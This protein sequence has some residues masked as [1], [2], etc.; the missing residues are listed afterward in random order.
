MKNPT[1]LEPPLTHAL[2]ISLARLS[3]EEL[4]ELYFEATT[5]K[6]LKSYES[7]HKKRNGSIA[8]ARA[9]DKYREIF[10][11]ACDIAIKE[12]G[13]KLKPIRFNAISKTLANLEPSVEWLGNSMKSEEES[14]KKYLVTKN[15]NKWITAFNKKHFAS[16]CNISK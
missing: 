6:A 14:R 13:D 1:K 9:N 15:V 11:K 5:T 3:K 12:M 8:K 2:R 10:E 7:W 4:I 16:K